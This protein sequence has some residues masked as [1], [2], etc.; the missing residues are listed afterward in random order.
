MSIIQ[1]ILLASII[2]FIIINLALGNGHKLLNILRLRFERKR[3]YKSP[4]Q[5][6][7]END[8]ILTHHN[9]LHNI[10]HNALPTNYKKLH[11][12]QSDV[13]YPEGKVIMFMLD[14]RKWGV[15]KILDDNQFKLLI[16]AKYT[17]IG[18]SKS[19]KLITAVHYSTSKTT[20]KFKLYHFYDLNGI[21]VGSIKGKLTVNIDDFGNILIQKS[22]LYGLLN[23]KFEY[24]INCQYDRLHPLDK[25]IFVAQRHAIPGDIATKINFKA[26]VNAKNEIITDFGVKA[27]I[28]SY[29][30]NQKVIFYHEE[31][32]PNYSVFDFRRNKRSDLNFD[33]IIY[34]GD[35]RYMAKEHFYRT[36][37]NYQEI[38]FDKIDDDVLPTLIHTR[39]NWGIILPDGQEIIP[40]NYDYIDV[41]PHGYFRVG[42]GKISVEYNKDKDDDIINAN[43]MKWGVIDQNNNIIVPIEYD[44][45]MP[46]FNDSWI[47]KVNAEITFNISE[48]KYGWNCNKGQSGV[49]HSKY[50]LTVPPIYGHSYIFSQEER[51]VRFQKKGHQ[52]NRNKPYFTFNE[53]GKK[54]FIPIK[55]R[56]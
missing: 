54:V 14:G 18:Y 17:S 47:V 45:I 7:N 53:K 43:G 41:L 51:L 10:Y 27:E 8:I 28:F 11:R 25:G 34:G 22:R 36:V 6:F 42:V 33:K 38:V 19:L 2:S 29:S 35:E 5:Y 44:W 21:C 52:F 23:Q 16:E 55:P 12:I 9:P 56:Q 40:P 30:L 31:S 3:F 32:K 46:L 1:A 24:A 39:G 50:K 15:L 26:I 13:Y 4:S 48:P 20:S 49:Y 37:S